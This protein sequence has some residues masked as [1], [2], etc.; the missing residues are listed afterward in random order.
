[1]SSHVHH[2]YKDSN[3][4]EKRWRTLY[5]ATEGAFAGFLASLAVLAADVMFARLLG[6]AP[7]MLLRFH[8]TLHEGPTALLMSD[9]TFFLNAFS[10]HLTLGSALGAVFV[11]VVSGRSGLRAGDLANQFLCTSQLDSAFH[12]RKGVHSGK[13]SVVGCCR[14]SRTLWNHRSFRLVCFPERCG[15]LFRLNEIQGNEAP[16]LEQEGWRVAPGW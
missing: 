9:R 1:M 4:V 7:F 5:F 13:H 6:Y 14:D 3:V 11:L 10:M 2:I 16:L 8:A 15:G 12:Q